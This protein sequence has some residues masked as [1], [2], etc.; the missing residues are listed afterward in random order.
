[1]RAFIIVVVLCLLPAILS[2]GPEQEAIS[3]L[4][5][6]KDLINSGDLV[7][8]SEEIQYALTK[9]NEIL[10]KQLEAFLPAAPKG[11][12]EEN[13]EASSLGSAGMFV[14]S[15]NALSASSSYSNEAG[16]YLNVNIGVGGLMGKAA[17]LASMGQMWGGSS[18]GAES[19]RIKGYTGTLEYDRENQSGKLSLQVGDETSVMIEG[20]M[21]DSTD[22]LRSLAESMDLAGL[23]KAF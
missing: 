3:S 14:G 23:E 21:I 20:S 4:D 12:N 17:G 11:Y 1:M 19:T 22:V 7:K 10:A 8:A 9:V 6:A 18:T 16:S 5:T 13:R 15:A 2:A